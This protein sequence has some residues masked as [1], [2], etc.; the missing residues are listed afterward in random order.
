MTGDFLV[1]FF[2]IL[3]GFDEHKY[4]FDFFSPVHFPY[5]E[6]TMIY[7]NTRKHYGVVPEAITMPQS[8]LTY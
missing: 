5:T 4:P 1:Y 3:K 6:K 8:N 2:Q 7:P